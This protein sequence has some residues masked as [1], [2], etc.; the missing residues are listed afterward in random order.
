MPHGWGEYQVRQSKP[1]LAN[2]TRYDSRRAAGR[3]LNVDDST[4]RDWIKKRKAG[5]FDLYGCACTVEQ[6]KVGGC[7]CHKD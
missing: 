3:A 5:F 7:K 1:V 2:W 6:L 4:I